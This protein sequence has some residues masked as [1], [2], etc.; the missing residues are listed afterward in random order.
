MLDL[1]VDIKKGKRGAIAKA[2]SIVEN[3]PKSAKKLLKKIF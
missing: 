3:N 2:I 1:L